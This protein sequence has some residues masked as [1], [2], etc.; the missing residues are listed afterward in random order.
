MISFYSSLANRWY[1]LRWLFGAIAVTGFVATIWLLIEF[2]DSPRALAVIFSVSPSVIL[3][4]WALELM[5]VQF[6]PV[7]GRLFAGSSAIGTPKPGALIRRG[8][9][10]VTLTIMFAAGA[11]ICPLHAILSK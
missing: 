11:V 9:R 1:H 3:I 2:R 4:F 10:A 8:Y 7:K 6:H 5:C